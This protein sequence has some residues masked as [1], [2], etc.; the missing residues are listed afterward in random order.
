VHRD[1]QTSAI[2]IRHEVMVVHFFTLKRVSTVE[3]FVSPAQRCTVGSPPTAT[4]TIEIA[5]DVSQSE[6][7]LARHRLCFWLVLA[8]AF[9]VV[10]H[11]FRDHGP[12]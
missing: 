3:L 12:G 2:D 8:G 7:L 10:P 9:I 1:L 6:E 11:C 4:D 5:I